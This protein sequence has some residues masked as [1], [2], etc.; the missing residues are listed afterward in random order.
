MPNCAQT[1][2]MKKLLAPLIAKCYGLLF[3]LYV[4]FSPTKTAD[5]AFHVF[6]KVRSGRVRPD[7]VAYLEAAKKEVVAVEGHNI[8]V[9]E[10]QGHKATVLLVHGWESNS[11]RWYK[12]IEK[13]QAAHFHVLAFDAPAHGHSTGS[14]LYV[15]L[16]ACVV[17][18][19]V[20]RYQPQHLVGHSVG[21]MTLLYN[22]YK[23]PN[24]DVEKMV[25]VAS[26]SEFHEIMSHYQQLLG[27]NQRVF[28]A[29]DQYVKSRFGFYIREFSSRTFVK[30]N[31]KKGLLFHDRY[32]PITPYHASVDV[33]RHWKGSTL[34]TTE[35]FGHS[36]HQDQVNEKILSF[37]ED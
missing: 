8:Q 35:G 20:Q 27:F 25:T 17:E 30:D 7:Q 22:A 14:Y 3:N 24:A 37:L 34:V 12:L 26:P 6:A 13:L 1:Q 15:P 16:Y 2:S 5:W 32:D 18:A 11:W 19:M 21:G 9:Y 28:A 4:L 36:L 29:L 23:N 33:Q 31:P 10:W